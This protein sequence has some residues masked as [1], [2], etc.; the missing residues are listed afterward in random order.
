MGFKK[1]L[2]K[3][4]KKVYEK[5]QPGDI[6]TQEGLIVTIEDV[7]DVSEQTA[8]KYISDLERREV[9]EKT[10]EMTYKVKPKDEIPEDMRP[11]GGE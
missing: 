6:M 11:E 5:K 7:H 9:M 4:L 8:K 10:S 2:R 3:V 1:R